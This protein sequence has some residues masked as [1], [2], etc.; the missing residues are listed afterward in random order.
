MLCSV[1]RERRTA[2]KPLIDRDLADGR[3]GRRNRA[4]LSRGAVT[5]CED[6]V[7]L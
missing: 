2:R 3:V 7:L 6:R 4:Q 5:F 1:V